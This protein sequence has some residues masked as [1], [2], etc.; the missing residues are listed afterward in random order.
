MERIGQI[1]C[2][3]FLILSKLIPKTDFL[4]VLA[5]SKEPVRIFFHKW[6]E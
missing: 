5:T 3:R 4:E 6:K 1:I 2:A